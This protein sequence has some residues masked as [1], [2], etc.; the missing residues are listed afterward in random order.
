MQAE[1]CKRN[2]VLGPRSD[3]VWPANWTLAWTH[4]SGLLDSDD[5]T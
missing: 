1:Q 5:V 2:V 3:C 4:E